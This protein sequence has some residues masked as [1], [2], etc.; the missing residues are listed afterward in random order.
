M[1]RYD[2]RCEGAC[3]DFEV[4]H[5][6]KDDALTTCPQCGSTVIRLISKGVGIMFAGSGFYANDVRTKKVSQTDSGV[7]TGDAVKTES[8]SDA[9][10]SDS[11]SSNDQSAST[12]D[13]SSSSSPDKGS[14][15][16]SST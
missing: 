5:S 11:A 12:K 9:N 2:Y 8:K 6:I 3:A 13:S 15:L 10:S 14:S 1:P 7:S 16:S 4:V